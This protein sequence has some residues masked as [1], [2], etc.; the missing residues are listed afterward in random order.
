[1]G[2]A[3]GGVGAKMKI[4]MLT[5]SAHKHGTSAALAC[6]N[7]DALLK[8]NYLSDVYNLGKSM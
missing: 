3:E 1:M 5:G 2:K 8:T 4:L 7:L 6:P